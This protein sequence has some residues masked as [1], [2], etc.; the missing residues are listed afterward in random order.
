M[1]IEITKSRRKLIPGVIVVMG[2][3]SGARGGVGLN[4]SDERER[5]RR[6]VQWGNA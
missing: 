2:P 1:D 3:R 4:S 5:L 6:I